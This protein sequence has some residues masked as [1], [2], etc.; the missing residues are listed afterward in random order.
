LRVLRKLRTGVVGKNDEHS[1]ENL[2]AATRKKNASGRYLLNLLAHQVAWPFP[3]I[4]YRVAE[5]VN[6]RAGSI[7]DARG[8][9]YESF[10]SRDFC[11]P[12]KRALNSCRTIIRGRLM[13]YYA[14]CIIRSSTRRQT[15][16]VSVEGMVFDVAVDIR[17]ARPVRKWVG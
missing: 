11:E 16:I 3:S 15:R 4:P 14:G 6:R 12:W 2:A 5:V 17:K 1:A 13:A 9:F 10:N 7:R 8:F